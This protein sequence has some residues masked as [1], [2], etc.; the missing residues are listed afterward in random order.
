VEHF[1]EDD[2]GEAL[3]LLTERP[4]SSSTKLK[5]PPTGPQDAKPL[6]KNPWAMEKLEVLILESEREDSIDKHGS[7]FLG[8]SQEPCSYNTSP[9][10][11]ELNVTSKY[12]D[13][14]HSKIF[15]CKMFRR[16]VVDAF[17]YHKFC[18]SRGCTHGSNLAAEL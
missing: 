10:S 16:M 4:L 18:K 8:K 3:H 12:K 17:V 14:N 13:H 9:E 1:K 11:D 2:S 7:F 5:S 6:K 15:I